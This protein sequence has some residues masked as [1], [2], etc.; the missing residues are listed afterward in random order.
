MY[1]LQIWCKDS[2]SKCHY[3]EPH[4]DNQNVCPNILQ[5][6]HCSYLHLLF[7][8]LSALLQAACTTNVKTTR[9]M[10]HDIALA[11]AM[12]TI[13]SDTNILQTQDLLNIHLSYCIGNVVLDHEIA[14]SLF[15]LDSC[16]SHHMLLTCIGDLIRIDH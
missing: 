11:Y 14:N 9:P 5:D 13:A 16:F 3:T 4:P 1:L 6:I 8:F 15:F 7:S 10:A 2:D 12:S